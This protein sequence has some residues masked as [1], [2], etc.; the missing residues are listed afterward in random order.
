VQCLLEKLKNRHSTN[1]LDW[2]LVRVIYF[3]RRLPHSVQLPFCDNYHVIQGHCT[4]LNENCPMVIVNIVPMYNQ[5]NLYSGYS[6]Q[7]R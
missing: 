4:Q 6:F 1:G 7:L 3:Q 2:E 5:D